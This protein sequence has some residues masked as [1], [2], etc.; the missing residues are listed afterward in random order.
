MAHSLARASPSSNSGTTARASPA[1]PVC[2]RAAWPGGSANPFIASG[3]S[4][5]GRAQAQASSTLFFSPTPVRIGATA[6]QADCSSAAMSATSGRSS[7]PSRPA[8]A[9]IATTGR[10]PATTHRAPGTA[11]RMRGQMSVAIKATASMLGA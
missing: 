9:W 7:M 4:A 2:T 6:I 3:V 8:S 10:R 11:A 1:A 5:T